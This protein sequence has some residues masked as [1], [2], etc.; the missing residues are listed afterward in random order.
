VLSDEQSILFFN[1]ET[2]AV[3]HEI[4]PP[5]APNG[6]RWHAFALAPQV[7]MLAI[8]G[9]DAKKQNFVEVWGTRTGPSQSQ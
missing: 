7:Y 9:I 3:K 1:T 2:W 5:D 8:G 6:G 4:G